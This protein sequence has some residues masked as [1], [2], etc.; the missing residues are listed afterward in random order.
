MG[1]LAPLDHGLDLGVYG[2]H[3]SGPEP[4]ALAKFSDA[5]GALQNVVGQVAPVVG[6]DAP[7]LALLAEGKPLVDQDRS[8][9]AALLAVHRGQVCGY[10]VQDDH[11]LA[12]L[13]GSQQAHGHALGF[14]P[15]LARGDV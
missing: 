4:R 14:D 3:V 13:M 2:L 5:A 12:A 15:I 6:A 7:R 9:S 8:P 1:H 10:G 11:A